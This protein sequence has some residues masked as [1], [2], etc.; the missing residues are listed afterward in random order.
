MGIKAIR[1]PD[2]LYARFSSIVD[3]FTHLNCTRKEIWEVFRDEGGIDFANKMIERADKEL[4]RWEEELETIKEVHGSEVAELRRKGLFELPERDDHDVQ[5]ELE[6]EKRFNKKECKTCKYRNQAEEFATM[7]ERKC[8]SECFDDLEKPNYEKDPNYEEDKFINKV[9]GDI[10]NRSLGYG[11]E[12]LCKH[13]KA[14]SDLTKA[15]TRFVI[16]QLNASIKNVESVTTQESVN[17]LFV[18]SKDGF[19]YEV[20]ELEVSKET[21]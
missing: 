15:T 3:D 11:I 12:Y 14:I 10:D 6:L 8:S 9:E 20:S 4:E 19:C 7:P 5:G 17:V 21:I 1:Q 18:M 13:N 2:G 16:S